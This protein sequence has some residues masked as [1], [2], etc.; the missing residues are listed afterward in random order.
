MRM[1]GAAANQSTLQHLDN[2]FARIT[3]SQTLC[4]NRF[5]LSQTLLERMI[6]IVVVFCLLLL[7]IW[8]SFSK[9]AAAI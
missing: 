1:N 8:D 5:S 6:R 2:S 9:D 3:E 7:F 4:Q